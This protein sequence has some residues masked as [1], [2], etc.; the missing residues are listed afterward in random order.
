MR[1]AL[2]SPGYPHRDRSLARARGEFSTV[3]SPPR[4]QDE[5]LFSRER[6]RA[7]LLLPMSAAMHRERVIRTPLNN[8]VIRR[9]IKV[10]LG[11]SALEIRHEKSMR[12]RPF[13]F[14]L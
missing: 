10:L 2:F 7:L 4:S 6:S 3:R 9:Q 11:T 12:N 5:V 14:L 13:P 1:Y 8:L